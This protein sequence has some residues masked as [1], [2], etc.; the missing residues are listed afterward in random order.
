MDWY[1]LVWYST[2]KIHEHHWTFVMSL[3]GEAFLLAETREPAG[4]DHWRRNAWLVAHSIHICHMF[5]YRIFIIYYSFVVRKGGVLIA[6]GWCR[7]ISFLFVQDETKRFFFFCYNIIQKYIYNTI[8]ILLQKEAFSRNFQ[9]QQT[10]LGYVTFVKALLQSSAL[11]R[12][13]LW[14]LEGYARC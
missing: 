14:V 12:S 4:K 10:V 7:C 6:V 11:L 1:G 9:D 3:I 5:E 2:K 13:S 8:Y